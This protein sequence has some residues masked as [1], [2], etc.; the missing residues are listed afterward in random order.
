MLLAWI[1]TLWVQVPLKLRHFLSHTLRHFTKTSVLEL[2]VNVAAR[3]QLTFNQTF[4]LL[5]K[6]YLYHQSRYSRTRDSE[7]LALIAQ[8]VRSF[9]MKIGGLSP[10]HVEIFLVFKTSTI[11]NN[12]RSWV[13]NEC[14]CLRTVNLSNVNFTTKISIPPEPVFK[15]TGM[16][17][18]GPDSSSGYIFL[19][20]LYLSA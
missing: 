18:S 3:A 16:Q 7:C 4:T 17:M 1:R 10:P 15:N 12:I 11:T 20:W 13:E 14:C 19:K 8:V 9:G 5:Q 6:K 2:K